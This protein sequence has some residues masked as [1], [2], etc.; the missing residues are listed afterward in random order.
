MIDLH[1]H[2]RAS[3]GTDRPAQVLEAAAV[4]GLGVVALTD[5]DTT[6]GW[7]E[8]AAAVGRTGVALVRGTEVSTRVQTPQG[9]ISVHLLSYLHD[10]ADAALRAEWQRTRDARLTRARRMAERLGEDFPLTWDDVLAQTGDD[11]TVGR[12]HLAD[13]LVAAGVA[14]SRDEA[15]ATMLHP[16]ARYYVPHY[17]PRTDDAVRAVL[18]AGGV[19]VLAHP[20]AG[21]RGRV[22][23][24]ETIADLAAAGLA[25]LEVDHR[26]HDDA[27][28][29]RLRGLARELG[30]FVTGS[31]DY[32][33]TGKLNRIGEHT[34]APEVLADIEDRGLLAVVRP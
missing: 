7:D 33:G 17:A 6:A 16:G 5:H 26:D 14:T 13:A 21:A 27:T 24:D 15:F 20:G 4:A 31:S 34:T 25:G 23:T 19:P 8:A 10:P 18:A 11:A 29:A 1:T 28:R 12:P 22:V 9:G 32:H 3:D 2:S 30:L